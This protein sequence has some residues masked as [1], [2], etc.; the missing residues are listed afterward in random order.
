MTRRNITLIILG[1][2]LIVVVGVILY[3]QYRP[4]PVEDVVVEDDTKKVTISKFDKDLISTMELNNKHGTLKLWKEGE[5]W[6][7][8]YPYPVK[9]KKMSVEDVAYSFCSLYSEDVVEE[10]PEDLAVYGLETP[11]ATARYILTDGATREFYLGNKTPAGNSY[12]LMAQDDPKVYAVWMNHGNHFQYRL[13]DIRVT[14][15]PTVKID[16]IKYILISRRGEPT[17]EIA[18]IEAIPEGDIQFSMSRYELTQPYEEPRGTDTENLQEFFGKI[19]AVKIDEFVDDNPGDLSQYGLDPPEITYIAEDSES[20][21]HLLFGKKKGDTVYFKE[22]GGQSVYTT[23]DYYTGFL[24]VNPFYLADKFAFLINIDYVE[25]IRLQ[26]P[27][28]DYILRIDRKGEGD[29]AVVTYFFNDREVEEKPFKT[30]YQNI[31]SIFVD[32]AYNVRI[33]EKPEF[34]MTYSVN[35]GSTREYRIAFVPYDVDFYAL[36]KNGASD[37]LVTRIQIGYLLDALDTFDKETKGN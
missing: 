19:S 20:R 24:S 32:S 30:I 10:K 17:V 2:A 21:V 13:D 5:E 6:K 8:N 35:T 14:D 16:E 26:D 36:F 29:D 31:L 18:E 28:R 22:A 4:K 33:E 25:S 7:V 3:L 12:Y 34:Q 1:A 37:F 15:M 23:R 27:D 11:L 9:L